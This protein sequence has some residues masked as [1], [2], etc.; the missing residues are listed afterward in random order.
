M[1]AIWGGFGRPFS[2]VRGPRATQDRAAPAPRE[3]TS[4]GHVV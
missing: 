3:R 4:R 1:S 2:I